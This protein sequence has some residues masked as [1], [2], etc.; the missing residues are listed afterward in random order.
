MCLIFYRVNIKLKFD[1]IQSNIALL[2]DVSNF[3]Q[4]IS[5]NLTIR[6]KLHDS[7]LAENKSNQRLVNQTKLSFKTVRLK[8]KH[9][10]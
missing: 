7:E 10:V 6:V 5:C 1:F 2:H 8:S 3:I 9:R 4:G